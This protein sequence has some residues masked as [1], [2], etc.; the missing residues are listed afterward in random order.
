MYSGKSNIIKLVKCI[1]S[2]NQNSEDCYI[3][4]ENVI[5]LQGKV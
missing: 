5:M 3:K 1:P 4:K 2:P